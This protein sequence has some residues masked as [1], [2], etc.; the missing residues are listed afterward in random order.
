MFYSLRSTIPWV[1]IWLLFIVILGY[2]IYRIYP[3]V[4]GPTITIYSPLPGATIP[5][6]TFI[7]SGKAER[8]K[9][10]YIQGRLITLDTEGVFN[11]T[12]VTHSPYTILVVEAV[13]K[14]GKRKM[15]TRTV[16]PE[17]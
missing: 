2:G 16:V 4:V 12:L 6:K 15:E 7:V 14:Y 3:R 5:E 9:E 13:D 1:S 17:K 8:A 10:V 11:E